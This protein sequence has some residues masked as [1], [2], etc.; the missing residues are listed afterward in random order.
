[1]KPCE[2]RVPEKMRVSAFYSECLVSISHAV[3]RIPCAGQGERG[4]QTR[5]GI[6][7]QQ[8]PAGGLSDL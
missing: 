4:F 7:E 2:S 3:P 6:V 8:H 5:F 1:M